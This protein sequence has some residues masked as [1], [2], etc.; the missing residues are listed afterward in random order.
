MPVTGLFD[1]MKA[2][3]T[4]ATGLTDDFIDD[5]DLRLQSLGYVIQDTDDWTV[6]FSI[7]KTVNAIKN[8][9]NVHAVPEGLTQV[10]VDMTCG[11]F[12][13][14]KKNSGQLLGFVLDLNSAALK[15]IQEGD[16][17]V[18]FDVSSTSSHEQRLDSLIQYL[19]DYGKPQLVTYRRMKW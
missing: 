19:L 10:A 13:L 14:T 7:H 5:V 2:T 16:T 17:N 4:Q 6:A 8:E 12:L 3:I 1:G 11:D 15:Q 18:V 9:C